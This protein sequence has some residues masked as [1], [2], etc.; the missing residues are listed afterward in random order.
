MLAFKYP[1]MSLS[2]CGGRTF[3]AIPSQSRGDGMDNK[4]A[5]VIA[6]MILAL[7]GADQLWLHWGIISF[8]FEKLTE[9]IDSIAFWR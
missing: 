3:V 2:P 1:G 7:L 8:V 5:L 9:L 4:T 6:L